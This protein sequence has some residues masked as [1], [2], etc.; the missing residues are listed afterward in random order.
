MQSVANHIPGA[1]GITNESESTATGIMATKIVQ[2]DDVAHGEHVGVGEQI[3]QPDEFA[4][5]DEPVTV[6]V[7]LARY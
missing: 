3:A 5:S 1:C 6:F 7:D 4:D 2:D